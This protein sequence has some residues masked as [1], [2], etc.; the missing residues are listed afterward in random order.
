MSKQLE[1]LTTEET[2]RLY[3]RPIDE[4]TNEEAGHLY[5]REQAKRLLRNL[6]ISLLSSDAHDP[7]R[8]VTAFTQQPDGHSNRHLP[9]LRQRTSFIKYR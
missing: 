5:R 3:E 2:A 7:G 8:I 6:R 4:L 1:Q 9:L